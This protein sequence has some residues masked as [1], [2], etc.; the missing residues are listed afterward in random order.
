MCIFSSHFS[1]DRV[2][3][4]D[5]VVFLALGFEVQLVLKVLDVWLLLQGFVHLT[6]S[7]LPTPGSCPK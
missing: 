7:G 2:H 1:L 6:G 5:I 4:G 3:T